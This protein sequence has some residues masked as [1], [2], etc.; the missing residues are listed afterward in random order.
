MQ[1][2]KHRRSGS[3]GTGQF[4][5][6]ANDSWRSM[7][8]EEQPFQQQHIRSR[9]LLLGQTDRFE[10]D[11]MLATAPIQPLPVTSRNSNPTLEQTGS[12]NAI[13]AIYLGLFNSR[14]AKLI[15]AVSMTLVA[16]YHV[17]VR[18]SFSQDSCTGLLQDGRYQGAHVWQPY[19]CMLHIYSR[20]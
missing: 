7:G 16:V 12:I 6:V 4:M 10:N 1:K 19:G 14:N 18:F 15:A 17:I 3:S 9:S 20:A 8:S 13:D 5:R 2:M 11:Q